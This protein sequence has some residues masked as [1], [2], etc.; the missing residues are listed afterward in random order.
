MKPQNTE[1]TGKLPGRI[2]V[3]DDYVELANGLA[4]WL[5]RLGSKVE[6]AFDG[7]RGIATAATFRPNLILLDIG[8][9]DI[10]GYEVAEQIRSRSWGREMILVAITA[11][12]V[13]EERSRIRASGFDAYLVKPLVYKQVQSLLAKYAAQTAL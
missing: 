1:P 9:P 5:R 4:N 8:L 7:S 6:V 2:L 12:K 13:A 10:T 3:I 11:H